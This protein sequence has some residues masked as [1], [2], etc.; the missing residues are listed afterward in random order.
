MSKKTVN[1]CIFNPETHEID[2]AEVYTLG[3]E[4]EVRAAMLQMEAFARGF[5]W[6]F[7]AGE[8]PFSFKEEP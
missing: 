8:K 1:M 3:E 6:Q 5:P 2:A 4:A 7:Y